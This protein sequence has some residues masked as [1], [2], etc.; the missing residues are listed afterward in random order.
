MNA[1]PIIT[2]ERF[3]VH[4]GSLSPKYIREVAEDF[5]S[6]LSERTCRTYE[7]GLRDFSKFIGESEIY[8]ALLRFLRLSPIEAYRLALQYQSNLR[9]RGLAS[10]TINTRLTALRALVKFMQVMGLIQWDL[11]VKNVRTE[12]Y[13]DTSGPTQDVFLRMLKKAKGQR[14]SAKAKRD[15]AILMLHRYLGLRR[16]AVVNLDLEDVDLSAGKIAVLEKGL[17]EKLI[18]TLPEGTKAALQIWIEERGDHPGALFHNFHR[19][20]TVRKRISGTGV[21]HIVRTL[22][23]KVG[24][25]TRPHAIRHSSVTDLLE[26]TNGNITG[27]QQFAGHKDVRTTCIYNDNRKDEAGQLA[28][29]LEE[30]DKTAQK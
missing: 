1:N 2:K 25:K 12:S 14:L 11:K 15:I 26:L 24:V 28:T 6:S 19:D 8:P 18:K 17:Q 30:W 9:E 20:I 16:G 22:G 13:R 29:L 27:V 23:E 5:F 10:G 7:Q 21:Y 3:P 4:S